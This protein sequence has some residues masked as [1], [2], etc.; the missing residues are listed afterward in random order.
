MPELLGIDNV[1]FAVRDLDEAVGFYETCGF[2]LRFKVEAAGMALFAIGGEE[3]AGGRLW[4]E[5]R[6][7]DAVAAEL[8]AAGIATARIETMTGITVE[9]ADASGNVVGFADY[10]RRPEMARR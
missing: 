4:V 3:G 8:M 9:A 7:A 5:V 2:A 1:L 6:D 10:S